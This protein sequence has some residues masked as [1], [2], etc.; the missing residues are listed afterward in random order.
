M[1]EGCGK[2][3]T[4][5]SLLLFK[6]MKESEGKLE[7]QVEISTPAPITHYPYLS[8]FYLLIK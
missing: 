4:L 1:V 8:S 5:A 6:T 3:S 7:V 2:T